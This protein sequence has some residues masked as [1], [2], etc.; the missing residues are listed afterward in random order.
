MIYFK[1]IMK[2]GDPYNFGLSSILR[3]RRS[4]TLMQFQQSS[5]SSASCVRVY[6]IEIMGH[7]S[8][9]CCLCKLCAVEQIQRPLPH[10]QTTEKERG[11][12]H[13]D[14]RAS[15]RKF[16][17]HITSISTG[18]PR[19]ARDARARRV[20][21]TAR[22]A[23]RPGTR[24]LPGRSPAPAT[25]QCP[26]SAPRAPMP[27]RQKNNNSSSSECLWYAVRLQWDQHSEK[28]V[29]YSSPSVITHTR[30]SSMSPSL[31][32]WRAASSRSTGN[33]S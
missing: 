5:S 28:E 25:F 6:A 1:S 19:A 7:T 26:C 31:E 15:R 33:S 17:D 13:T 2:P 30:T 22:T 11:G 12:A 20:L 4:A 29:A 27:D 8:S 23:S 10:Y 32:N 16:I 18:R 9:P 24:A 3:C 14:A 21:A